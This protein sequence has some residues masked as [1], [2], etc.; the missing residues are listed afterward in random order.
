MEPATLIFFGLFALAVFWVAV[1]TSW[2]HQAIQENERLRRGDF[3][4]EEFQALCHH[5]DKKP[6]CTR[7]DFKAGCKEYQRKLF[8]AP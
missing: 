2:F 4:P 8:G 1:L 3:T 7:K 6:G 5:R